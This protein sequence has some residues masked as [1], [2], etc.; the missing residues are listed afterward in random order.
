MTSVA[1]ADDKNFDG[2]YAGAELGYNSFDFT[3]GLK[4]DAIYYGGF[5]GYRMQ[6]DNNLVFGLEGRFGDSSASSDLSGT[7]EIKAG[8]QLGVDATLGYAFGQKK[9]ILTYAFVGY[10]DVKMTVKDGNQSDSVTGD[11]VRFGLGTEY[12]LS[13]NLSLRLTGAYAN[14]EGNPSDLQINAGILYRF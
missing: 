9:D 6:M 2:V 12:V 10:T 7:A 13:D 1:Q 5:V 4:K 3:D 11:G 8:R 14:Y